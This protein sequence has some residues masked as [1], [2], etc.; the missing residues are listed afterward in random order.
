MLR[1]LDTA[2][3][4]VLEVA[5]GRDGRV[6]LYVCGP[7]VYAPPHVGHGRL[8]LVYDV[9]RRYLVHRG[10]DVLYVSNVTDVD[11]K[12]I[13]RAEAERREP[14]EIA[15]EA[16]EQW[17]KAMGTLG[18]AKPDLVPHATEYV[19]QMVEMIA[20]LAAA[21]A[22]YPTPDGV[23][24]SVAAVPGYGLLPH[25]D[26][27]DLRAGAR[28][29]ADENKRAPADFALWKA[30]KPGEPSWDSPFG[31]GRPGWHTE[32]VVMSLALL[33]EG[34]SLHGGGQDLIFPHHENE[35]AQAVA[36]GREF[37]RL[38]MHNGMV[39]AGGEKMSKS[40][41]NTLGLE[42]LL[43][44]S[45]PRA[46][47]MLVL[48]SHYRSPLEV[49]IDTLEDAA[50]AVER[51]DALARRLDDPL[52]AGDSGG[53][54]REGAAADALEAAFV[55]AMDDDLDTPRALALVLSDGVRRAN[56]L[57]DAGDAAGARA[58]GRRALDLLAALGL[59][60]SGSG[61]VTAPPEVVERARQRDEARAGGDWATAD[62]LRAEIE[63]LGW[64]VE[65]TPGG[66]RLR[67]R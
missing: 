66:A 59:R 6:G 60:A 41:G 9:L 65:D 54:G 15:A 47:R 37:A 50:R 33:G 2:S 14:K 10:V 48:R 40:L 61:D 44:G 29:E 57:A 39:V 58:L 36:L 4:E 24:L 8:T 55:A 51:V 28:V 53:A 46:Y 62:V 67:L 13:Q 31:P 17:W 34:F 11:D 7:T 23:Y 26:P 49:D 52:G 12:I 18:A 38:W 5:P 21:G 42:E 45:D 22:A 35:R 25:L 63:Q 32:C 16:E 43:A 1:L 27:E 20:E 30:A 56:A 64:Q 3:R 19:P